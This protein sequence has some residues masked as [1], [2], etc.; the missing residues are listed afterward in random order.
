MSIYHKASIDFRLILKS[1]SN[2]FLE[3]TST[4]LKQWGYNFVLKEL[5]A[6]ATCIEQRSR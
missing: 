1:H 4:C 5:V 6:S 2:A 3:P